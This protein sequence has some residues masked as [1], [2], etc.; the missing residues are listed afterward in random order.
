MFTD[1]ELAQIEALIHKVMD[2]RADDSAGPPPPPPTLVLGIPHDFGAYVN[3]IIG[4]NPRRQGAAMRHLLATAPSRLLYDHEDNSPLEDAVLMF[5]AEEYRKEVATMPGRMIGAPIAR[6]AQDPES[7]RII[8]GVVVVPPN[9]F[10]VANYR[11]KTEAEAIRE[12][13]RYLLLEAS[14][15]IGE[16]NRNPNAQGFGERPN[17]G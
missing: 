11:A 17:G 4:D 15:A 10:N 16:D 7:G 14:K 5:A 9:P 12:V 2:D 6:Q 13:E 8:P 3:Q 1:T